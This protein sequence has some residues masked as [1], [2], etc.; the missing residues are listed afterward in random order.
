MMLD[1]IGFHIGQDFA[2][3]GRVLAADV[4]KSIIA[5]YQEGLKEKG[6][7]K[8]DRYINKWLQLRL[9]AYARGKLFS[10]QITPD[11]IRSLDA[12]TCPITGVQLTHAT[13]K[14]TDW[15]IDRIANDF[16]Y[17]PSNLI[18]MSTRA[19]K[20]KG[21]KSA[22]RIIRISES[23]DANRDGLTADE[24][25]RMAEL[26]QWTRFRQLPV[27]ELEKVDATELFIASLL[28]GEKPIHKGQYSKLAVF[29]AW[30][31]QQLE[32]ESKILP[33]VDKI[34]NRNKQAKLIFHKLWHRLIKRK[35]AY[36]PEEQYKQWANQ[37]T[38]GLYVKWVLLHDINEL[39][40]FLNKYEAVEFS[41]PLEE[42][43]RREGEYS[44]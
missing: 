11:Y 17:I 27:D 33:Q 34:L 24:W 4:H 26:V 19:N 42:I 38:L 6:K 15:S 22:D 40:N 43:Q 2:H 36:L 37:T 30:L 8:S 35:S 14:D 3:Y 20:A 41:G 25:K 9:N 44:E 5:G 7:W 23:T 28:K 10:D 18:V 1:R 39:G 29:Q 21:D 13:G 32:Q 12:E 31:L 16:D